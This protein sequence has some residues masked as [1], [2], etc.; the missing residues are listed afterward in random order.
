MTG[1]LLLA[2][3]VAAGLVAPL[4]YPGSGGSLAVDHG[5]FDN[6]SA[7]SPPTA[8]LAPFGGGPHPL[9]QT[10]HL[11]LDVAQG[12]LL[13]TRWDL[14][15]IAFLVG[16]SALVGALLGAIAGAMGGRVESILSPI[17][18]GTLAFPPLM[19][20]VTVLAVT[21]SGPL[22]GS[23]MV[24][25]LFGMLAVLWAPFAQGVRA[26][27]RSTAHQAFVEAAKASGARWPRILLRHIL[28]NCSAPV[29]AQVPSSVF[30][31]FFVLGFFQYLGL[32]AESSV[33]PNCGTVRVGLGVV[34]SIPSG[35]FLIVPSVRFP[36][37]TWTLAN[38]LSGFTVGSIL[39]E[40]WGYLLPTAWIALFLLAVTLFCDGLA[41]HLSPFR[42]R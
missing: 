35:L 13:G 31:V 17:L 21:Y 18:D 1:L 37:W 3:F 29:L 5:V 12:L 9:G 10:A 38:G 15:L 11:G 23:R 36:E 42:G 24:V 2:F 8:Q 20:M 16:A 26:Q 39:P 6:C 14:L 28:P 7:P 32:V 40:W 27:A 4:L 19:V 34:H 30:S 33:V 41:A 22:E 25:F